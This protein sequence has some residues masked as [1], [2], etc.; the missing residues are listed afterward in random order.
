MELS[1]I[2]KDIQAA[3]QGGAVEIV[4]TGVQLGGWG[5]DFVQ[6]LGLKDLI[7]HLLELPGITRL[8]LSSIEPWDFDPSMLSLWQDKRLCRQLHI[9]LQSGSNRILK[10]MGRPISVQEYQDLLEEVR[11]RI[12][13]VA[14]TTDIITGFPG[15]TEAD[16]QATVNVINKMAYAGGHV[17]TYSPRLGTAAYQMVDRVP[18]QLA[19]E[20]NA[21]LRIYLPQWS[22]L[23]GGFFGRHLKVL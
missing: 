3:L 8:R 12:P 16:F 21:I 17:F 6:P 7:G 9:P 20:R 15:E 5:R 11:L 4:L 23:P 22:A 19:K 14:I 10:R 1:E 13:D 18:A 2:C